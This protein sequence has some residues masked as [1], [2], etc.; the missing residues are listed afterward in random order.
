[1]AKKGSKLAQYQARARSV[2]RATAEKQQHTI[3]AVG[4][5]F[6]I[7]WAESQKFRLP[8]FAGVH[9][10]ALYGGLA[11]LGAYFIRDKQFKRIAE[12]VADGLLSVAAHL[13][14]SKGFGAVFGGAPAVS[15]WGEE[16][17]EEAT[18]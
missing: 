16:I 1:M 5:A 12:S 14:G 11:L 13:A 7:G 10:S 9:P 3:V 18:F 2:A 8:T 15:G 17:I 6:G 4:T